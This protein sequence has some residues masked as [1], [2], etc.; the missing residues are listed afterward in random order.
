VDDK[1]SNEGFVKLILNQKLIND[2][3]SSLQFISDKGHFSFLFKGYDNHSN[4]EVAIKFYDPSKK[5]DEYRLRCFHREVELL[6]RLKGQKNIIQIVD[7]LSNLKIVLKDVSS[8]AEIP[9]NYEFFV[10]E[11][12][13]SDIEEYIY[14]N[15]DDALNK[16]YCFKE[17]CKAVFRIHREGICHRDL[18]PSNFLICGSNEIKL[19]DLGTAIILK[20]GTPI[21]SH[22][23]GPVGDRRYSA[24]ELFCEIGIRDSNAFSAD[25]FSLGAILFEM[26]TKTPLHIKVYDMQFIKSLLDLNKHLALSKQSYRMTLFN[27]S[28][29]AITTPHR[30]PDI[31]SYNDLVPNSI[32]HNLNKIYKD[33][34]HL[35]YRKRNIDPQSI[36]RQIDI[37]LIILR[38]QKKEQIRR[39]Y[40]KK[41]R[42]KI[43]C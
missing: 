23:I 36:L 13:N 27:E 10:L 21:S 41:I 29:D 35:N 18:K 20:N 11:L 12:A 28:I 30:L 1:D 15:D 17:L 42:E 6:E 33:M 32:K 3:Y 19:S 7:G 22:Y 5:T 34:S 31:F 9:S 43:I 38:N 40:K 8:G 14:S 24:P 39:E 26:F 4:S 2:R 25:I 37:C 16:L